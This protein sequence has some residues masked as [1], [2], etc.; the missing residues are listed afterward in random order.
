MDRPDFANDVD[1]THEWVSKYRIPLIATPYPRYGYEMALVVPDKNPD[2]AW[3]AA[4]W[5]TEEEAAMIGV[6]IDHRR[7][8]YRDDVAA[9]M[10]E[11]PLDVNGTVNT[12]ILIKQ[13][14]KGSLPSGWRHRSASWESPLFSPFNPTNAEGPTDTR[15]FAP[16][17][18][19]LVRILSEAIFSTRDYNE[20][21]TETLRVRP[22]DDWLARMVERSDLF[23]PYLA[24]YADLVK[25]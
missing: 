3:Y 16:D 24:P 6:A 19:G 18:E 5:P 23:G 14:D 10:L 11:R 4:M 15:R 25:G 2:D 9:K 22:N 21:Y 13:D 20:D 1:L 8:W 17:A 7:A 12:F